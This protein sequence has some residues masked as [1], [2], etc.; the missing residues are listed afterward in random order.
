MP[1]CHV[2]R[3]SI[4][5]GLLKA[6]L[7]SGGIRCG[8][9]YANLHFAERIGVDLLRR[10]SLQMRPDD[11][12]GEWSFAPAAFPEHPAAPA[13]EVLA[14]SRRHRP[15]G[16]PRWPEPADAAD[17][18]E[19]VRALTPAFVDDTAR[20]VLARRPR[21]V[22]CTSSFEQH[23]ASLALLRRVKAL[24]PSVIT[25][26][27]GANC[28]AEMGWATVRAFPWVDFVVSGEADELIAPL[29][30]LLLERGREVAPVDLPYGVMSAAHV[31]DEAFGPGRAPVPRAVVERLDAT[32]V[33]DYTDYFAALDA[34]PLR[35]HIQPGL[36]IETSRGCWWG[37]KSQCTFCGLNGQGMAYRAKRPDR[38]LAEL[39]ELA[40]RY[41]IKSFQTVDNILDMNHLRTVVPE[42]A[43]QGAPYRLF[44]ETKSNLRREQV[45][46]LA[47]AGITAVQPG[48][49][50][51]HDGFLKLI[52]KGNSAV[53]NVQFLKYA[54]EVGMHVSWLLLARFPGED[55]AWHH[56][57][58]AWLPRLAHLQPPLSVVSLRYDR[59]GVYHQHP[60]RFGLR[61]V[62]YPAYARIYPVPPDQLADLAY[63]FVDAEDTRGGEP[64]PGAEALGRAVGEW[65]AAFA[66]LPR[67][68]LC[69]TD[70]GRTIEIL[71][72]RP[73]A[74]RRHL[75]LHGVDAAVYRACEPAI[76][77]G[78]LAR[79][80]GATAVEAALARL[81]A[82]GLSLSVHGKH[83]ALAVPG[84]VPVLPDGDDLPGGHVRRP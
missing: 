57:V 8:V 4:A 80:L 37:Q 24:D 10:L 3:P 75:T 50:G 7:T 21:V 61:L 20:A 15:P 31:R 59:F 41:G 42:L 84:E 56:E 79:R 9:E 38:V 18:Y 43:R 74:R 78:E 13:A 1:Y 77:T 22:G 47:E 67:P 33:P 30:R 53:V 29:C 54:R 52:A 58:A 12:M 26:L 40:G 83:L 76:A 19:R 32:P 5:L 36:V 63:F 14:G 65:R 70:T 82:L 69:M 2:A 6:A 81:D 45:A 34:S 16:L 27:G 62:P 17:V 64:T 23:T 28:E 44:Y 46:R 55:D 48:I 66:R 68:V 25:L 49:E 73:C 72:T 11:L 51:L 39:A 60:G 35:P 71:D